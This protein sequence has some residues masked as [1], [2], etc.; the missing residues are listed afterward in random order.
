MADLISKLIPA[1]LLLALLIWGI[2]AA[3]FLMPTIETRRAENLYI[4]M[5]Q[6]GE[7]PDIKPRQ[8]QA[9]NQ[10]GEAQTTQ[11]KPLGQQ[12]TSG[13]RGLFNDENA[14]LYDRI[15]YQNE[16]ACTCAVYAAYE[17][18]FWQSL[19]N[20]MTFDFY[21]SAKIKR[22]DIEIALAKSSN[23]CG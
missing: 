13:L 1:P 18:N 14:A 9:N 15:H 2:I 4:P 10:S 22:F 19:A 7:L 11:D 16:D 21:K 8:E 12:I 23:I 3:A 20:V 6:R 17:R 5:C